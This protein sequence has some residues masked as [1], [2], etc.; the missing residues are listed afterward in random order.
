MTE[1]IKTD[2]DKILKTSAFSEK[3]VE[4]KKILVI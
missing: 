1:Q 4:L 3:D 2:F